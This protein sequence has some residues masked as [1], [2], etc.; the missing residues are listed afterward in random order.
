MAA[1]NST[2]EYRD[3]PGFPGYRVGSDGSVWSCRQPSSA[4]SKVTERWRRLK[5]WTHK[6]RGP[7]R[8]YLCLDLT[9]DGIR[10]SF[11]VHRLIL[12]AFV[13]PR[14]GG[15]ECRHLDGDPLNNAINNLCWGTN[16]E[17]AAD[18]RRLGRY[19][20]KLTEGQVREIRARYAAGGIL[21][22]ELAALYGTTR[23]N[24]SS[25]INRASWRHL[26]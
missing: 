24:V 20:V 17:N 7:G 11:L 22:R 6:K 19:S 5:T 23:M 10:H 8:T 14:P 25:I 13:G 3:V 18:T 21:Q 15:A 4:G 1:D 26:D 12:E 16:A 9:R 2:V